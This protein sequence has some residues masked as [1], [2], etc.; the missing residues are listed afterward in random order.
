MTQRG[1]RGGE[2]A[3]RV[4]GGAIKVG[5][6]AVEGLRGGH[7]GWGAG[8]EGGGCQKKIS[9]EAGGWR[10][11]R[12][13]FPAGEVAGLGPAL[14]CLLLSSKSSPQIPPFRLYRALSVSNALFRFH[15]CLVAEK[16]WGR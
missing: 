6:S 14:P 9:G 1:G 11:G 10:P 2:I 3:G 15:F 16:M 13:R 12:R 5:G 4:G 7:C 8:R